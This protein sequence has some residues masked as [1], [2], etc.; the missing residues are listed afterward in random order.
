[1]KP[2]VL[3][4]EIV[5]QGK[6]F[7]VRRDA[8][9]LPNGR[10]AHLDIIAHHG[11]VTMLPIDAEGNVWFVRQYRHAAGETILELPAGT[12]EPGEPPEACAARELQEEIGMAA[13]NLTLL[14]EFYLAPGYSTEY[15]YIYLATGLT[16]SSLPQD[17][18]EILEPVAF[19]YEEVV[20]MAREGKIRD[21]KTLAALFLAAA[22]GVVELVGR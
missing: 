4:S 20:K 21:A 11:A 14:G 10:V 2:E 12:L 9:R 19:P 8:V 15:Q 17:A 16:P 6:V 22:R 1:M 3:Q 5:F 18:D 7:T 13:E